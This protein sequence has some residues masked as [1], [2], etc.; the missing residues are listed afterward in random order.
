MACTRRRSFSHTLGEMFRYY[1]A[2]DHFTIETDHENLKLL[3]KLEKPPRLVRWAIEL[4]KYSFTI[5]PKA[6]K[7][8]VI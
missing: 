5:V 8:N 6:G 2:Y 1:V 3:M 7:L 4:S